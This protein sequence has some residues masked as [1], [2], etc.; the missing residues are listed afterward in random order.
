[1]ILYNDYSDYYIIIVYTA[2]QYPCT[3]RTPAYILYD[4]CL[5]CPWSQV[6]AILLTI[7]MASLAKSKCGQ[8]QET[9]EKERQSAQ[10]AWYVCENLCGCMTECIS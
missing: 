2:V 3:H 4:A 10:T 8:K 5:L 9:K 7:S 6:N 1:M